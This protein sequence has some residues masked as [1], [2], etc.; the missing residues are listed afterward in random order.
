M[1]IIFA[2]AVAAALIF[3]IYK[4]RPPVFSLRSF[5]IS[6]LNI[7]KAR[8]VTYLNADTAFGA[9]VGNPNGKMRFNFGEMTV[10]I[11]VEEGEVGLG[12]ATVPAFTVRE[13]EASRLEGEA[14]V[15]GEGVDEGV[16]GRFEKKEVVPRVEIRTSIGVS[17][18]GWK[19]GNME[20]SVCCGGVSWNDMER[21]IMPK[22]T[23]TFLVW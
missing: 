22:C 11:S 8:G 10:E 15:R 14:S 4:P 13:K 19:M 2:F 18:Q 7:T 1:V 5:Q 12:W 20:V 16:K 17:L 6:N 21:G 3:F 23:F 9:E